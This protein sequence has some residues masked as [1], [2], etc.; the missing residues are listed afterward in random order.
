[1]SDL[2]LQLVF[3]DGEEAFNTWNDADS[4]YGARHMA[5]KWTKNESLSSIV[6]TNTRYISPFFIHC[7]MSI[8]IIFCDA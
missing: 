6:S 3:F 2:T 7:R 4:I 1:M 5:E 8:G